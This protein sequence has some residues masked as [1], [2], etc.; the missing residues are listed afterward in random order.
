MRSRT[1]LTGI[2]LSLLICCSFVAAAQ[3]STGIIVIKAP[4]VAPD[5]IT[6]AEMSDTICLGTSTQLTVSGGQLGTDAQWVWY[7]G[8]CGSGT[9]F[10]TG[11]S[12]SITPL[13]NTTYYCTPEGGCNAFPCVTRTVYVSPSLNCVSLPLHLLSF[14]AALY[15]SNKGLLKWTVTEDPAS[16]HYILEESAD[17]KIFA[18]L[19]TLPAHD[20]S[21]VNSYSFT[22]E[23]LTIGRNV[24][25]LKQVGKDGSFVYAPL[26][27][28]WYGPAKATDG[29]LYPNPTDGLLYFELESASAGHLKIRISNVLAQHIFKEQDELL[30]KG[31]N[32]IR[33]DLH[34]LSDGTYLFYYQTD[35]NGERKTIK[36]IKRTP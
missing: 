12:V 31:K 5:S 9:P 36:F 19:A 29:V 13:E 23:H 14:D 7:T 18:K 16:D 11:A 21:L 6:L 3:I 22:D 1:F 24:Y 27:V 15:Q 25:R 30:V 17:G 20:D 8:S 32:I 33:L 10:A 28:L 26:R 2:I 34:G 4:S 35:F